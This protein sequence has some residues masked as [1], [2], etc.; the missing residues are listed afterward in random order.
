M[1]EKHCNFMINTVSA[2]A[3]DLENLGDELIRRVQEE[4]GLTLHWEIKRIGE[5]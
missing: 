5:R 3:A 2:T 4:F 1:S